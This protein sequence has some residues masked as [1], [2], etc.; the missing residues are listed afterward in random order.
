MEFVY[1]Q[2]V[3]MDTTQENDIYYVACEYMA[4]TELFD[5]AMLCEFSDPC[6]STMAVVHPRYRLWSY[7]NSRQMKAEL[8]KKY[9]VD[10][11]DIREIIKEH[12]YTAQQWINEWKR[13]KENKI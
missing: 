1:S 8:I 2:G 5:R 13:L 4:R 7:D 10:W 11:M 6:D 9:R 12:H 3:Y